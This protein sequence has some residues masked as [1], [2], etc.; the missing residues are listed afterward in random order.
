MALLYKP[1]FLRWIGGRTSR[2]GLSLDCSAD[3]MAEALSKPG[4]KPAAKK[5]NRFFTR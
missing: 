3:P 2:T 1:N 5:N 4:S